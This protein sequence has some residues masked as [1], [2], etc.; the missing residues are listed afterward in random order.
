MFIMSMNM[1]VLAALMLSVMMV[2]MTIDSQVTI[3]GG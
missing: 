1:F 3:T 2:M